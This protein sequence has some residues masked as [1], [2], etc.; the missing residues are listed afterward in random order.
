MTPASAQEGGASTSS[1]ECAAELTA[2]ALAA[3][4]LVN[5]AWKGRDFF[6]K[7][8]RVGSGEAEITV[9]TAEWDNRRRRFMENDGRKKKGRGDLL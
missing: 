4:D 5:G 1:S 3:H 2:S 9:Y 7:A 6:L 8:K